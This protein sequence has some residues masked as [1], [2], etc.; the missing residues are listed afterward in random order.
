[1]SNAHKLPITQE[2]VI[3]VVTQCVKKDDH[4]EV[5]RVS[6]QNAIKQKNTRC[7]VFCDDLSASLSI[8][9]VA[10]LTSTLVASRRVAT[11][12]ILVTRLE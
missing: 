1:M 3:F 11:C 4:L 12:G 8:T 10:L 5:N 6:K 2:F 7:V 9:P